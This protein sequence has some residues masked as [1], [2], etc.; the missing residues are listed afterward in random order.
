MN[1]N[2]FEEMHGRVELVEEPAEVVQVVEVVEEK[3]VVETHVSAPDS[4]EKTELDADN[5]AADNLAADYVFE[6]HNE[7]LFEIRMRKAMQARWRR[8]LDTKL[9]VIE[10]VKRLERMKTVLGELRLLKDAYMTV[11][12]ARDLVTT[13]LFELLSSREK[14]E[15]NEVASNEETQLEKDMKSR[16]S[17]TST[18][19]GEEDYEAVLHVDP[20]ARVEPQVTVPPQVLGEGIVDNEDEEDA[21]GV[22]FKEVINKEM[23][24]S[25][26]AE[27]GANNAN[28]A[29]SN[30]ANNAVSNDA[31]NAVSDDANNAVS[32][33]ANNAVSDVATEETDDVVNDEGF[34]HPNPDATITH[35]PDTHRHDLMK[36]C[37]RIKVKIQILSS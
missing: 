3:E 26:G 4:A 10:G 21:E 37:P 23:E 16:V 19:K 17:L 15:S 18:S 22:K 8:V 31:N 5:L 1:E 7:S 6:T 35:D 9:D 25:I 11:Q 14:E 33:D 29:V 36:V 32:D 24:E 28:N 20:Q 12:R 2:H 27:H 13:G 30:D 34:D